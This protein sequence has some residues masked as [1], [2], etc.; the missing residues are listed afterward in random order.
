MKI[1]KYLFLAMGFLLIVSFT[2]CK[3]ATSDKNKEK[4]E[5][6][7]AFK[8]YWY[9]GKAEITSYKLTQ[10]RYGEL[11]EGKAVFI[12]VTEPFLKDK[13]VKAD[14]PNGE[15]TSVLKLNSTKNFNT[16][17]YPYSIMNSTFYPLKYKG[18][19]LKISTSVTEWCGQQYMQLNNKSNFK[20]TI[21]SYFEN[22]ADKNF[23]VNKDILEDELWSQLR[24]DP[25]NL[26]LGEQKII[27]S[28]QYIRL[29]H[30]PVKAYTA[31][32]TLKT[33][34]TI[35]TYTLTY[36][37]LDRTLSINFQKEFPFGIESWKESYK[38]GA[39]VKAKM[40]TSSG[41]KINTIMSAYWTKNSTNDVYLRDS[42]GL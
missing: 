30:K 20:I 21:H 40:L 11:R 16:G 32:A 22:E 3:L 18:H 2:F 12:Y 34:G 1:V 13:Q 15:S 24:V 36:P 26:P 7:E 41:E 33:E 10:A 9:A 37:E 29:M 17:I 27:P 31:N 5:L 28:F 8:K 39:G 6:S 14:N 4:R 42:L 35:N 19:A 38:S 23:S 25:S